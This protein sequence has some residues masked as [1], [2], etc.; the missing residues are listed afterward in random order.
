MAYGLP[1]ADDHSEAWEGE[2]DSAK[3]FSVDSVLP[4]T[5]TSVALKKGVEVGDMQNRAQG[6]G[7]TE[8]LANQPREVY[9]TQG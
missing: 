2:S 9:G 7:Q 8:Q 5:Q 1:S 4:I 3:V 6:Q